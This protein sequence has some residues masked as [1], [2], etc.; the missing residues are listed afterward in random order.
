LKGWEG[1]TGSCDVIVSP[2]MRPNVT[3]ADVRFGAHRSELVLGFLDFRKN[4][5]DRNIADFFDLGRR[6]LLQVNCR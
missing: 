2:R 3:L 1:G 6:L 5:S 4:L